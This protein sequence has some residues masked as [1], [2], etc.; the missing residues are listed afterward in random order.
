MGRDAGHSPRSIPACR[1]AVE[2]QNQNR[3]AEQA[4]RF[5]GMNIRSSGMRK[6]TGGGA[7][8]QRVREIL[9]SA[10]AGVARTV[11]TTQVI[12]NWLIGREIVHEEQQGKR[13]AGYGDML[14]LDLAAKLTAEFGAGFSDT[15]LRWFRQFFL[16]YEDLLA[17]RIHHAVRDKSISTRQSTSSAIHHA[18]RDESLPAILNAPPPESWR[19]G[20]LNPN[21]SWTHY[22]TLLRVEN[23]GPRS[24]YEIESLQNNWS[25]RELERQIN[26]LLYERLALSRD[27]K[28]LLRLARKGQEI[29]GPL[30][31]FKDPL[32]LEFLKIPAA[33]RLVESDLEAA[34]LNELQSFLLELGKG[35]AFVARQERITLD[36]DH[37]YVD[38]VFYH[39]I[40]KCFVLLDLKVR[41]LTHEDLGQLQLYLNHYDRERRTGGDHPTL[42]LILCTDKNDAMVR[43]TLGAEQQKKIFASRY[44]LHLPS[45]AELKAELLRELQCLGPAIAAN[46]ETTKR[47]TNP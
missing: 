14:L 7:L 6:K 39:T 42:G 44:K 3:K 5:E 36:G 37:F 32:V 35:F 23:S 8:Y 19:P 4:V 40:L 28:G 26:S 25:A 29:Q 33:A 46:P 16:E 17:K 11:N 10:R 38:L 12:A 22:R 18:V 30:D 13:K 31:V 24:F 43:Y 41:K 21:L 15:N 45:E 34:L 1:L 27:K 47:R 9:E 2:K 20:Q